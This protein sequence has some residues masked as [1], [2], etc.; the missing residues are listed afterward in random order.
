MIFIYF[1]FNVLILLILIYHSRHY[2]HHIIVLTAETHSRMQ[3]FPVHPYVLNVFKTNHLNQRS[4]QL[5]ENLAVIL[6][7][8]LNILL[9]LYCFL[10]C[11]TFELIMDEITNNIYAI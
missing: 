3:S 1:L 6:V 5:K 8:L 4:Q 9:N 10:G 7:E 11:F 2:R